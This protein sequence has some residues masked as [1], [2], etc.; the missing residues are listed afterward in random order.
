MNEKV[1]LTLLKYVLVYKNGASEMNF[2]AKE[3]FNMNFDIKNGC[4]NDFKDNNEKS[5]S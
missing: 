2:F 1:L 4:K 5:C 3:F